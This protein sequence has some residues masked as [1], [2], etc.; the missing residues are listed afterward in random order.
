M[1][2]A[3]HIVPLVPRPRHRPRDDAIPLCFCFLVFSPFTGAVRKLCPF[4]NFK[5]FLQGRAWADC[6]SRCWFICRW[7]ATE[8][9]LGTCSFSTNSFESFEPECRD[10]FGSHPRNDVD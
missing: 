5:P 2:D 9:W 10:R 7:P 6:C 4:S 8:H 1:I 3:S